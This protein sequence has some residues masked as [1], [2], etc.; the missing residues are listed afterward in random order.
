[1]LGLSFRS[2]YIYNCNYFIIEFFHLLFLSYDSR[3]AATD[4]TGAVALCRALQHFIH[5]ISLQYKR[6][7][8]LIFKTVGYETRK[9]VNKVHFDY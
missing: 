2:Q 8:A 7:D 9:F 5:M 3:Q 6:F 4:I 1:V